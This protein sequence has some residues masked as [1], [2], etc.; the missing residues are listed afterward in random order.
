MAT[1]RLVRTVIEG[2]RTRSNTEKRRLSHCAQRARERAWLR[3][4]RDRNRWDDA[5]EPRVVRVRKSFADK[6]GPAGRWL[7][8]YVD[9]PWREVESTI[10]ATF[11]VSTLPGRHIV[12]GHLLPP[13][14][15]SDRW[16]RVG[17]HYFEIDAEGIFRRAKKHVRPR[18]LRIRAEIAGWIGARR[19][20]TRGRRAFWLE[21]TRVPRDGEPIF[22]RQARELDACEMQ[23]LATLNPIELAAFVKSL[24]PFPATELRR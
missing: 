8:Q 2:G 1:K 20:G 16:W 6:L 15:S 4:A 5:P 13:T 24:D 11:D 23:R 7:A 12:F 22:Y 3:G 14:W 18:R 21:R 19:I 9:R 17:R 10:L